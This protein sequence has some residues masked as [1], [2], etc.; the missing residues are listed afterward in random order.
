M[1]NIRIIQ[2]AGG[3][4]LILLGVFFTFK[5][6]LSYQKETISDFWAV[7]GIIFMVLGVIFLLAPFFS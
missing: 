4:F 3:I 5:P 2:V 7:L 1:E 6:Q